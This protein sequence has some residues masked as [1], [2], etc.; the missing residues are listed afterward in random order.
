MST[1]PKYIFVL[2]GMVDVYTAE[3]WHWSGFFPNISI[4]SMQI[5][6]FGSMIEE[7]KTLE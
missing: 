7:D 1:L 4:S 5:V 2:H 6:V 3:E